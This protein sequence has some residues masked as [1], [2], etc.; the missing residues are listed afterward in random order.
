MGFR[1]G[2]LVDLAEDFKVC[3][4]L[5]S[6]DVIGPAGKLVVE[7]VSHRALR[8]ETR[9][10]SALFGRVIVYLCVSVDE[11]QYGKSRGYRP[12]FVN[13]MA[14][15]VNVRFVASKLCCRERSIVV[16]YYGELQKM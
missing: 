9:A 1:F 15:L 4:L 10:D 13:I 16:N 7:S 6:S 5:L 3:K 11:A 2:G 8:F 14:S 12:I